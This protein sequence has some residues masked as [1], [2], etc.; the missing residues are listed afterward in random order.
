MGRRKEGILGDG[1]A[2]SKGA[3]PSLKVRDA[4]TSWAALGAQSGLYNQILEGLED[5]LKNLG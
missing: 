1:R 3:E 5:S 2:I 4:G